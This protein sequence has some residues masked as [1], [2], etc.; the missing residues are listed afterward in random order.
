MGQFP[1]NCFSVETEYVKDGISVKLDPSSKTIT[2][3]GEGAMY[4]Y[5]PHTLIPWVGNIDG[6]T[7]LT[8]EEG[9]THIAYN[10]FSSASDLKT[11]SFPSTLESIGVEAFD[12]CSQIKELTIP[13]NVILIDDRAFLNCSSIK[14]ISFNEELEYIGDQAFDGC[15][16]VKEITLPESVNHIGE[17]ALCVYPGADL[18][19]PE[20]LDYIGYNAFSTSK[21]YKSLPNGLNIYSGCTLTYKGTLEDNSVTVP[22]GVV[23]LSQKTISDSRILNSIILPDTL[24]T[25]CKRALFNCTNLYEITIP[26]SVTRI[27]E[28]GLGYFLY[29]GTATRLAPFIIYGHAGHES[30]RY[31][32]ANGFDFVCLH[33]FDHYSY[34]PDCE[35]GG[36]AVPVCKW[37]HK[38]Y[39][40]I[41]I[42]PHEHVFDKAYTVI[43]TCTEYGCIR[44]ICID[45]GFCLETDTVPENGHTLPENLSL[46]KDPTC[47][48]NGI[49]ARKCSICGELCDSMEIAPTGHK[50]DDTWE[51]IKPPTCTETGIEALKCS[52]CNVTVET[53]ECAPLGH[54]IS[55]SWNECTILIKSDMATN[56]KGL[57]AKLCSE[58]GIICEYKYFLEGD[59]DQNGIIGANDCK[60]IKE[61]ISNN[62]Y[63]SFIV[64]LA[65]INYDGSV[66]SKD[67]KIL[68]NYL[69]LN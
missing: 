40:S 28:E 45:C 60:I 69:S 11:V 55:E 1:L 9:I 67:S 38:E 2:V 17:R 20:T 46:I 64:F 32:L 30:E 34:Y 42:D 10:S 36:E 58:C 12:G 33:E 62:L 59:L 8:I 65:D 51:C 49:V 44:R 68:K 48:T 61:I 21:Y 5:Y 47:T 24:T 6:Y 13:E 57:C 63:D 52:V 16:S 39:E 35:K 25:V 29:D 66:T 4:E 41:T 27:D 22:E 31:A 15:T 18:T 54:R 3:S 19:L 23:S 43:P 37:C 7:T 14:S 53:R 50:T 56:T 26:D